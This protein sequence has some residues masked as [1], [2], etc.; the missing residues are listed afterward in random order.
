MISVWM[1]GK[2]RKEDPHTG[3]FSYACSEYQD[4]MYKREPVVDWT[5]TPAANQPNAG[6]RHLPKYSDFEYRTDLYLRK[7]SLGCFLDWGYCMWDESRFEAWHLVDNPNRKLQEDEAFVEKLQGSGDG[8][9]LRIN[10]SERAVKEWWTDGENRFRDC[11]HCGY[12]TTWSW[13]EKK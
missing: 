10:G 12:H 13:G 3:S 11:V 2:E 7:Q 9:K 8:P 1:N 4:H 6:F 5:D